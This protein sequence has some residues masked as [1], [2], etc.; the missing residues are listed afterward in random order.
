VDIKI[1]DKHL[2]NIVERDGT[3]KN[4]GIRVHEGKKWSQKQ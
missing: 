2:E 1:Q 4:T 3:S